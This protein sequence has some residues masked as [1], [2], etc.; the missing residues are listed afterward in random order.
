MGRIVTLDSALGAAAQG[1]DRA[2][3]WGMWKPAC[4]KADITAHDVALSYDK[5]LAL[6]SATKDGREGSTVEVPAAHLTQPGGQ[7]LVDGV[8]F[9]IKDAWD[10]M[11]GKEPEG[12]VNG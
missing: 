8:A 6:F 3:L 5:T 1:V 12:I 9:A 2:W 4:E 7:L 11:D 10:R